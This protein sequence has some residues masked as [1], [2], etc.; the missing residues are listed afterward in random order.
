MLSGPSDPWLC[1]NSP[2]YGYRTPD[3]EYALM[4]YIRTH[5]RG[6][7]SLVHSYWINGVLITVLIRGT[8]A[9]LFGMIEAPLRPSFGFL[10]LIVFEGV[11]LVGITIWQSV[12]IWRS[13]Q[14]HKERTGRRVWANIAMVMVVFGFLGAAKTTS[15]YGKIVSAIYQALTGQSL[16]EY[17]IEIVETDI[18]L[19][20]YINYKAVDEIREL[21]ESSQ[22]LS[23]LVINSPGGFIGAAVEL[24]EIVQRREIAVVVDGNCLSG[25]TLLLVASPEPTI[26][27]GSV[28]GF[29]RAGGIGVAEAEVESNRLMEDFYT[30]H[31][32]P[33]SVIRKAMSTP[34][35]EIWAPS[36][37]ELVEFNI[38]MY[39]FDLDSWQFVDARDW[40]AARPAEC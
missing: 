4:G 3:T 11:V 36:L 10:A 29:H 17:S 37:G 12:G 13:A 21:L 24:S 7:H 33:R 9:A 8:D 31:G 40:C 28:V 27:P 32:V 15:D 6:E 25:C 16:A 39:V 1:S 34:Y 2:S 35:E 38:I 23:A 30:S 26:V 14:H 19:A 20:G 5:W 22:N 18:H